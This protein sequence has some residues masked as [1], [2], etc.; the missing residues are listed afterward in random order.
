MVQVECSPLRV[1]GV[2][3][4]IG[5]WHS[6]ALVAA[7]LESMKGHRRA[8]CRLRPLCQECPRRRAPYPGPAGPR[9][10]FLRP[11]VP[12]G[13]SYSHGERPVHYNHPDDYVD[14]DQWVVNKDVDKLLARSAGSVLDV[15]PRVPDPPTLGFEVA[16]LRLRAWGLRF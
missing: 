1:Q 8:R 7:A 3:T 11:P 16:G 15:D 10:P 9:P 6:E 5:A 4:E 2:D 12:E 14:S 13:N